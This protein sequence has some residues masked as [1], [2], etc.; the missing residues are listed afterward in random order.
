MPHRYVR[1]VFVTRAPHIIALRET[2]EQLQ[3]VSAENKRLRE[4]VSQLEADAQAAQS[5]IATLTAS[6]QELADKSRDQVNRSSGSY[7]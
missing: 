2:E 1:A 3:G 7:R 6:E 5:Q 4:R